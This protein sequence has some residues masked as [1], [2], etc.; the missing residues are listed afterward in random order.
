M[1][2]GLLWSQATTKTC[3]SMGS[4]WAHKTLLWRK[5]EVEWEE[6]HKEGLQEVPQEEEDALVVVDEH[7]YVV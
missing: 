4:M 6:Q 7:L 3:Q 2:L 5:E 1:G